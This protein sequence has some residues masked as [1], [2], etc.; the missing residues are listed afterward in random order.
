M[1]GKLAIYFASK[2]ELNQALTNLRTW[3]ASQEIALDC[4]R[5]HS[6]KLERELA[7]TR[8]HLTRQLE[9]AVERNSEL[10]ARLIKYENDDHDMPSEPLVHDPTEPLRTL[11]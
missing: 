8:A 10:W 5:S 1:I 9:A 2:R 11:T 6:R 7:E 4:E 3:T